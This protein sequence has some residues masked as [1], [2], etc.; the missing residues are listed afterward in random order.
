M[1]AKTLDIEPFTLDDQQF[2][3]ENTGDYNPIHLDELT[4]RSS[5]FGQIVVHGVH[6]F[7]RCLEGLFDQDYMTEFVMDAPIRAKVNFDKPVH[8]GD[9]L[10]I[11]LTELGATEISFEVR[12]DQLKILS[13]RIFSEPDGS[14]AEQ[15][16]SDRR[17]NLSIDELK[18]TPIVLTP[19]EIMESKGYNIDPVSRDPSRL[20]EAF[21][22]LWRCLGYERIWALANLST[23]VG[24]VMPGKYSL[25]VGFDCLLLRSSTQSKAQ[26][27]SYDLEDFHEVFNFARLRVV[28]D[29]MAAKISA[30]LRPAPVA[31]ESYVSLRNRHVAGE[32]TLPDLAGSNCLVV[33]ASRG[34]GALTAKLLHTAGAKVAFTYYKNQRSAESLQKELGQKRISS[35]QLD[36]A[37][38]EAGTS[39]LRT[40]DH[41]YYFATPHIFARKTKFFDVELWRSFERI[42]ISG[43]EAVHAKFS[44]QNSA[45]FYP[46]SVEIESSDQATLEYRMSKI[47]GEEICETMSK[48]YIDQKF[49]VERLPRLQTDQTAKIQSR[50]A[51]DSV[52][53]MSSIIQKMSDR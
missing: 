1:K 46:S 30:V 19:S 48:T 15:A 4:A 8:L 10:S 52:A 22:N 6:V 25:F 32:I 16:A 53:V 24:M 44:N 13:A 27:I 47:A 2:F 36:A 29:I 37:D 26:T 43:F 11:T 35:F 28:S 51:E 39:Q 14:I 3:A 12:M 9:T 41:I 38:L 31:Q 45:I 42:Y 49:V 34:L 50:Q 17:S 33:G 5:S 21:P 20:C 40:F 18:A 23:L 7:L